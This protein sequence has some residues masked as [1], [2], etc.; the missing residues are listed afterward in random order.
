ME[1]ANIKIRK[2]RKAFRNPGRYA[3]KS[4]TFALS[5]SLG[6]VIIGIVA[7]DM[8][9]TLF[10]GMSHLRNFEYFLLILSEAV[11]ALGMMQVRI[12]GAEKLY[13]RLSRGVNK[14]G[15]RGTERSLAMSRAASIKDSFNH[16]G[17]LD[18]LARK[19]VDEWEWRLEIRSRAEK[20]MLQRA[21]RFFSLPTAAN[22][23][24]YVVG[25]LAIAA[26]FVFAITERDSLVSNIPALIHDAWSNTVSLWVLIVLPTVIL[27]IPAAAIIS[28][29]KTCLERFKEWAN[30]RYLGNGRFY[31]F[32]DEL[33]KLQDMLDV[34]AC[35]RPRDS[36]YFVM[37]LAT[38]PWKDIR[39]VW[40]ISQRAARWKRKRSESISL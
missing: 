12:T 7:A 20:S 19:L 40:A 33:L 21:F 5:A 34:R 22:F 4:W 38:A 8:W 18:V 28:F 11:L 32:V 26:A 29:P 13:R 30:G 39:S 25:A 1:S 37:R 27:I 36:L 23:S 17:S 10:K 9:L 2:Y 31:R 16:S 6:I 3:L 15:F 24:A 35:D 14:V